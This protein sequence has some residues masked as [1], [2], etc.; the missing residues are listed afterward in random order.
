MPMSDSSMTNTL[1]GILSGKGFKGPKLMAYCKAVSGGSVMSQVGKSFNTADTGLIPG[2]GAGI[3]TGI[4]GLVQ[5]AMKGNI[6]G[7]GQGLDQK[8]PKFPDLAD[9]IATAVIAEAGNA[10]LTSAHGPVFLGVGVVI[11]G[12]IPVV[13]SEWAGN[14]QSLGAASQFKGPKWPNHCKAIGNGCVQSYP[15]ATGIV[16]ISGSFTGSIPP[17]PLPGAGAGAGVV[18]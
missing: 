4:M 17:G 8:G 2:V 16:T 5:S 12:S 14:I 11:P 6:I 15:T 9:G 3:G 13:A 10:L 1:Y 18:S 7:A